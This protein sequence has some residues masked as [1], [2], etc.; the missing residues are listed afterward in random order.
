VEP[1]G[2]LRTVGSPT[3]LPRIART[4]KWE[5]YCPIGWDKLIVLTGACGSKL[6]VRLFRRRPIE[7]VG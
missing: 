1:I 3:S 4:L 7:P 6:R 5:S 2:P